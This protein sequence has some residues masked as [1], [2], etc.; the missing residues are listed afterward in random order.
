MGQTSSALFLH[1][2]NHNHLINWKGADVILYCNNITKRN[3][4]ESA[5]IK[6]QIDLINVSAGLYKLDAFV[7]EKIFKL[8]SR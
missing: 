1:M 7:V 4:I 5:F 3:I 8:V 2:E 6:H